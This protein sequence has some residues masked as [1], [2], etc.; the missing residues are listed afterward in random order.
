MSKITETLNN[1]KSKLKNLEDEVFI[2]SIKNS[3]PIKEKNFNK[4]LKQK[5][6]F[7]EGL[8]EH[9]S[10]VILDVRGDSYEIDIKTINNCLFGNVLKDELSKVNNTNYSNSKPSIFLDFDRKNFPV[11]LNL[12]VFF[13]TNNLSFDDIN[14]SKIKYKIHLN[15]NSNSAVDA[16]K[17]L[18]IEIKCFFTD[19]NILNRIEYIE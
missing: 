11:F 4:K 13:N 18:D 16:R 15:K 12:L 17:L 1:L 6:S 7:I 2:S 5:L 3:V 9:N 8:Q 19:N 14:D 10:K